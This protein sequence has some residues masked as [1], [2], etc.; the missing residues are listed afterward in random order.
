MRMAWR[1]G[2]YALGLGS[3]LGTVTFGLY[4]RP[5]EVERRVVRALRDFLAEPAAGA[6]PSRSIGSSSSIRAVDPS[7][8]S[9]GWTYG[10]RVG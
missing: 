10:H 6:S 1:T 4:W 9:K 2:L 8:E 3:V 7:R 5:A